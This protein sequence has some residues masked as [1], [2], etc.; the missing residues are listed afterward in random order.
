M[1]KEMRIKSLKTLLVLC[2][3]LALLLV[4]TACSGGSSDNSE[5]GEEEG[6]EDLP[7]VVEDEFYQSIDPYNDGPITLIDT[8]DV[9]VR[10]VEP[11]TILG[12]FDAGDY[13]IQLSKPQLPDEVMSEVESY[14]YQWLMVKQTG[15]LVVDEDSDH[16]SIIIF[17]PNRLIVKAYSDDRGYTG[18]RKANFG[19]KPELIDDGGE[20]IGL[21]TFKEEEVNPTGA[22]ND[23]LSYGDNDFDYVIDAM[24]RSVE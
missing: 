21:L 12:Q 7:D 14:D 15:G 20:L 13:Q 11:G 6:L 18:G 2:M 19:F 24:K 17:F 4:G 5:V 16:Y 1:K 22:N 9:S 23:L 3:T 10:D 8:E